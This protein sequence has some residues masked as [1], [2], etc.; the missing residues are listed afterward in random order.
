M[1]AEQ[2]YDDGLVHGHHWAREKPAP[3]MP[4]LHAALGAVAARAQVEEAE[5]D[6][7]LVHAH[8]WAAQR[9]VLPAK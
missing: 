7:G 5:F 8:D 1:T 6:D 9:S 2:D 3:V 4:A